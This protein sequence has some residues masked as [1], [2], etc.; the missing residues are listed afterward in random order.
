MGTNP[1]P[2]PAQKPAPWIAR[3]PILALDESV[4]GYELL[5]REN[6]EERRYFPDAADATGADQATLAAIDTLNL[7]GLEVLCDGRAAFIN[8]AQSMLLKGYFAMLPPGETVLE[9]DEAVGADATVEAACQ[10][11]KQA[12]YRIALDRFAP[13]DPRAPLLDYADFLKVDVKKLTREDSAGL[14]ARYGTDHR[15]MLA[16]KVESR[17]DFVTAKQCG[18]RLFQG[19]FFRRPERLQ[20]R[21]IPANQA[22]FLRLLQAIAKPQLDFNEIED[23]IKHEPSLCYRLLR[24]LNSPLLG[25][26]SPVQ[27]VRHALNLLG[28]REAVRW[29]RMAT[30]LVLGQEKTSDLVLASLVRARFCELLAPKV[31]HGNS[32][33]FLL[34]MLSLMDAILQMPIG[35]VV[36][37]LHLD[38]GIKAQLVFG[39]TG[40]KT[41]LS[42]IYDLMV[43]REAGDWSA[44]TSLGK[45]LNLSL[46]FI[47][48]SYNAAMK[49]G[50]QMTSS[51]R[52]PAPPAK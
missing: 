44:V 15:R 37:D 45:Q 20:A 28:E 40:E 39:K 21:Q 3:Q 22:T 5:F 33:L 31:P 11:L 18:Y 48:E 24:Y 50:H 46:Y 29:I 12:G 14:A 25:L 38:A 27:S 35:I 7:L 1:Q 16:L 26:A 49:W 36:E 9:I 23:L 34:G 51:T 8:C 4:E 42:P 43:A 41:P 2:A 10:R 30:T 19:Y 17:Q 13:S 6:A 32:D 52:A 47:A